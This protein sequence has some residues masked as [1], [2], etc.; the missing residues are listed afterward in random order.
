MDPHFLFVLDTTI[1]LLH[2][3]LLALTCAQLLGVVLD[4]TVSSD[5][6]FT[7]CKGIFTPLTPKG[8]PCFPF[9]SAWRTFVR[10]YALMGCIVLQYSCLA[11]SG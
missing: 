11:L 5:R 4:T 8:D 7:E 2:G 10:N 9:R 6:H 3:F 1:G